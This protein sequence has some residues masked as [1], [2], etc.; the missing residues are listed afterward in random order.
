MDNEVFKWPPGSPGLNPQTGRVETDD[1]RF[2]LSPPNRKKPFWKIG[3][4]D[5]DTNQSKSVAARPRTAPRGFIRGYTPED[6]DLAY[7]ALLAHELNCPAPPVGDT[8]SSNVRAELRQVLSQLDGELTPEK[9]AEHTERT[10]ANQPKAKKQVEKAP[11]NADL[12]VLT[13]LTLYRAGRGKHMKSKSIIVDCMAMITEQC[14]RDVTCRQMDDDRQATIVAALRKRRAEGDDCLS[15]WTILTRMK[16]VWS[17]MRYCVRKKKLEEAAVPPRTPANLWEPKA[18]LPSRKGKLSDEQKVELLIAADRHD[19]WW[20]SLVAWEGLVCRPKAIFSVREENVMLADR[21]VDL[22]EVEQEGVQDEHKRKATVKLGPTI[23]RWFTYWIARKR[24]SQ[25]KDPELITYQGERIRSLKF[26]VTLAKHANVRMPKHMGAYI[27]RHG[28]ATEMAV[29]GV[30]EAQRKYLMGQKV[31][32]GAHGF[33]MQFEPEYQREAAAV[34]EARYVR[35][36]R[37]LDKRCRELGIR[38]RHHLLFPPGFERERAEWDRT[39]NETLAREQ[40]VELGLCVDQPE[41]EEAPQHWMHMLRHGT[42]QVDARGYSV[43]RFLKNLKEINGCSV[44][45]FDADKL[46]EA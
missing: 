34:L 4:Y 36:Q 19:H 25:D 6:L 45:G 2:Y 13:C 3:W 44:K 16:C 46:Y 39:E 11:P 15:D 38:L 42:Y 20:D 17:A 28:G 10:L 1:G 40:S 37:L 30:P 31:A 7:E 22:L 24:A 21:L 8:D 33:Y 14:G 18:H 27:Y 26:H 41:P 43:A 23:T 35:L 12:P 29:N 9:I 5:R 32:E